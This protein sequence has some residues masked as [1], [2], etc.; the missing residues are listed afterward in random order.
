MPR[1]VF[2]KYHFIRGCSG[3]DPE[4]RFIARFPVFINRRRLMVKWG[5]IEGETG[6]KSYCRSKIND[7]IMA[8]MEFASPLVRLGLK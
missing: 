3:L 1:S 5:E 4:T 7:A 6:R 8:T 2:V